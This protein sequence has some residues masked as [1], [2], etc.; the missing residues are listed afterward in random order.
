MFALVQPLELAALSVQLARQRLAL[1]LELHGALAESTLRARSDLCEALLVVPEHL[2]ESLEQGERVVTAL[3]RLNRG[4][5]LLRARVE[6]LLSKGR[7]AT[8]VPAALRHVERAIALYEQLQPRSL[9]W[10]EACVDALAPLMRLERNRDAERLGLA[11]VAVLREIDESDELARALVELGEVQSVLRQH[12]AAEASLAEALALRERRLGP[13]HGSTLFT[14]NKRATALRVLGRWRDAEA[15]AATGIERCVAALGPGET[16]YQAM[17]RVERGRCLVLLGRLRDADVE[18]RAALDCL[19]AWGA[20][21]FGHA[22]VRMAQATAACC[23]G[24]LT[25]ADAHLDDL[26]SLLAE[27]GFAPGSVNH[28]F[29]NLL[30]AEVAVRRGDPESA[31]RALGQVRP[32]ED[33][34]DGSMRTRSPRAAGLRAEI[35]LLRGEGPLALREIER[36]LQSI[37]DSGAAASAPGVMAA[38]HETH[39]RALHACTR[40]AEAAAAAARAVTLRE[41]HEAEDSVPLQR[42]RELH[43][44]VAAPH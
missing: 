8:D 40:C 22:A 37:A 32:E 3:Q 7:A 23:L 18:L 2:A 25:Q 44:R 34:V 10:A 15:A 39:A 26:E 31:E 42:A 28:D 12:D 24:E 33:S 43:Q 19:R 38:L 27:L 35:A 14:L 4:E 11:A 5:S 17:L 30:R 36:A 13:A 29:A 9:A 41:A 20:R 6:R 1:R 16:H 21:N